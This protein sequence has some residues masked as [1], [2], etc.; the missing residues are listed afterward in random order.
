MK[1]TMSEKIY[2]MLDE[3]KDI[4][5]MYPF[6]SYAIC[7]E[8]YDIAEKNNLIVEEGYAL[9]GM[10]FACRAK[11]DINQM[12]DCS[13]K[14][15]EIF[16]T[17]QI[18]LGKIKSLN[19]I[20]IAY[21]YNAMYEDALKYLLQVLDLLDEYKDYFLLSCVLN[22]IGEVLRESARYEEALEYYNSA[23]KICVENNFKI[24]TASIFNNIGEIY[25]LK[26]KYDEALNYYTKG[27]E[28]LIKEN[29]MVMLGE[30]ENKLGKVLY[31]NKDYGK[32]EEYLF[33]ALSR[34]DNINNKFY[35][36]DVLVNIAKLKL[37]KKSKDYLLYYEKALEYSEKIKAKKKISEVSKIVA[38]CYE[39]NFNYKL[40]LQYFKKYCS[41]NDEI[42]TS[43][44]GKKLEILKI[45]LKHLKIKE[46]YERIKIINKRLETE[47]SIQRNE[48]EKIQKSNE[49]LEKKALE[50]ELTCIPNRRFIN[51]YLNE[52]LEK[53]LLYDE[54][55]TLFIIDI[56][57][58]KKYNDYWGHSKGDECLIKVANCLKD[59]QVKRK[60]IV[61]R[62]GGEEFIYYA[63]GLN[64]DQALKLGNLIRN[65]VE[66]LSLNYMLG[67]KNNVITISVGGILGKASD[68]NKIT[69]MIEI[70]DEQLYKAKNMGRNITILK[71]LI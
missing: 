31:T 43:N 70:A 60:D 52:T 36:I 12:L 28:I 21:F 44:L 59:I 33:S 71:S 67:C 16:E 38:D 27:Y 48:L 61:G 20:G 18:T 57:N 41:V 68:F 58:F 26:N 50:D 64:Y 49:I 56:D 15:L 40:A 45:E 10:S 13:Y 3:A 54:K 25:F 2:K 34:L 65:E 35:A 63:K 66:K 69:D 5:T 6:K 32:A 17:V 24:N 51:Y 46:R 42:M 55:I 39:K 1:N 37:E 7:K 22:N 8:A 30:V 53:H 29:D 19:L 47:I 9:I 14:A 11:S 4:S 62:Y 23:L